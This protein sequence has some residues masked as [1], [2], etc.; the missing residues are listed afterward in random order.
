MS[1]LGTKLHAQ[2]DLP[3]LFDKTVGVLFRHIPDFLHEF[4]SHGTSK[5]SLNTTFLVLITKKGGRKQLNILD[6]SVC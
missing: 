5:R 1:S 6:L 2:M 4:Y 3:K